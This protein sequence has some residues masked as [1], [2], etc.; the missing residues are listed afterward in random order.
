MARTKVTPVKLRLKELRDAKGLTQDQL[1]ELSGVDQGN[2]SK[3]ERG[4]TKG[5]DFLTLEKLADAL[6]VDAGY[7]IH[8]ERTTKRRK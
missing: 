2:I 6:E 8:H 7:L 1:A 4:Q 3:I 5:V